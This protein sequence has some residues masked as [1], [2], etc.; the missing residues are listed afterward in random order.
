MVDTLMYWPGVSLAAFRNFSSPCRGPLSTQ[1]VPMTYNFSRLRYGSIA[2]RACTWQQNNADTSM[3]DC[4]ER[5]ALQQSRLNLEGLNV[6]MVLSTAASNQAKGVR[7]LKNSGDLYFVGCVTAGLQPDCNVTL[8]T[9][10]RKMITQVEQQ[11]QVQQQ[12]WRQQ[13]WRQEMLEYVTCMT[14]AMY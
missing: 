3:I 10:S 1:L 2:R 8:V 4:T 7:K 12:G 5:F 14:A 11:E 13:G 6:Y 9:W